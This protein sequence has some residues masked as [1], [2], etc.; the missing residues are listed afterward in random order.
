MQDSD[1]VRLQ[2]AGC[3]LQAAGRMNAGFVGVKGEDALHITFDS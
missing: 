3:R 2:A 1:A